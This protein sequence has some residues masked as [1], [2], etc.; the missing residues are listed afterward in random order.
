MTFEDL[1]VGREEAFDPHRH[2]EL[3]RFMDPEDADTGINR[4]GTCCVVFPAMVAAKARI[5]PSEAARGGVV[6][7]SEDYVKF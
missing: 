5:Q 1:F 6:M 3:A 4:N 2:R 7:W